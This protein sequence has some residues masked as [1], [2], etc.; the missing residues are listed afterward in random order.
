MRNNKTTAQERSTVYWRDDFIANEY[1]VL[2]IRSICD[3]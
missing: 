3:I 2:T 1:W